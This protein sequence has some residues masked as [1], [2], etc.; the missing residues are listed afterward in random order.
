MPKTR[1]KSSPGGKKRDNPNRGKAPVPTGMGS[2]VT[3]DAPRRE[4]PGSPFTLASKYEP[5]GDQPRAID[6]LV[7][8]VGAGEK[9]QTLLGVTG[10]G[11]T[12]T[13]ANVIARTGRPT[14]VISHNKTLAAQ[15]YEELCGFF[16]ENAVRFFVSYYDYYQPEAYKPSSDTYISKE[17]SVNQE[18]E[19]LRHAATAALLTRP[20]TI[21]VASV[22]CIYGLG[23]PLEYGKQNIPLARGMELDRDELIRRLV[24]I[25]YK[26]N[27]IE[28]LAGTFRVKGDTVEIHQPGDEEILRLEFWGDELERLAYLDPTTGQT[29][30]ELDGIT[31][32]PAKHFV[33]PE[34]EMDAALGRI[35]AQLEDRLEELK[36]EGKVLEA[37][38]LEQRTRFDMEM[39]KEIG[40]CNGIENYSQPL[41]GR[42]PGSP[43]WTLLDYFPDDFLMVIDE[44]HVTVPQIRGMYN[45]DRARKL[46]LVEYG[47]RLPSAL[48]NRPLEFKEFVERVPQCV[49]TSATPGPYE[50]KVSDRIAEQVIRPTGLVD[51][52]VEVRPQK[53]QVDDLL[54]EI[55]D[56]TEKGERVLVTTLTKR[57]AEDLTEYYTGAGVNVEYLHSDIDTLERVLILDALRRGETDVVV[58]INL[59]REGLDLPE[60]SLVAILDADKYGFLRS[61]TALIQTIGRAARNVHG[62]VLMYADGVTPAMQ[63]A[64]DTTN[65]RR[66]RQIEY[67]REHGI[68]PRS[69]VRAVRPAPAKEEEAESSMLERLRAVSRD[70]DALGPTERRK[71]IEELSRMMKEAARDLEF[72]KAALLRD[73]LIELKKEDAQDPG[74]RRR[75]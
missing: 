47:F 16:P 14:L 37:A 42:E 25:H 49:F 73:K 44:S 55:R 31:V 13:M 45:G 46:T 66:E 40:Y 22:S 59:L 54:A 71:L 33:M 63:I 50:R 64:L 1:S 19:R 28:P 10:S 20:D 18:I 27:N 17:T 8:G 61:E 29:L 3:S 26:R 68:T 35:S 58:G 30:R 4:F 65:E 74:A 67:N 5:T 34:S 43:P 70:A 48:D 53:G 2:Q 60:V 38:R 11:K 9:F 36:G 39:L 15:L 41:S 24:D 57:M 21:V 51:P 75:T 56:R 32:F 69:T 62:K 23:D 52:V 6:A 7:E 72:E 12:F